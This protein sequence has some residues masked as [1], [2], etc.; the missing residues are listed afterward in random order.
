MNIEKVFYIVESRKTKT[1]DFIS[2][3]GF[4]TLE[5][6][7]EYFNRLVDDKRKYKGQTILLFKQT[8]AFDKEENELADLLDEDF[9]EEIEL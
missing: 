2:D 4:E 7:K 3:A 9:I 5:E 1:N 6:A 8:Y